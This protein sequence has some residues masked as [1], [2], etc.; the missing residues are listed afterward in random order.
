MKKKTFSVTDHFDGK[1]FLNMIPGKRSLWDVIKWKMKNQAT[2]WPKERTFKSFPAPKN[3]SSPG[4][5]TATFVN[6]STVL[7]QWNGLN[8][9]TDPIWSERC[10]PLNR[11]GPKRVHPPGIAL[12]DLPPID[13]I[14]LSHNHYDHL[15]LPTLKKIGLRDRPMI[16][17]GLGIKSLLNAQKI[18]RVHE[19]DWLPWKELQLFYV[20]AQHFSGRTIRTFDKSLWGGFILKMHGHTLYFAGDTGDGPHFQ[21]IREKF[22]KPY[23]SLLP[24]GAY[25]PRWFTRLVHMCPEEAVKAHQTLESEH[26]LA[27]HFGT[28]QL[29]DE[30]IDEPIHELENELK[31]Q[32]IPPSYFVGLEPGQS[33]RY[34]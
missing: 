13:L 22:G 7:I 9:I 3:R 23:L 1:R 31:K 14:L 29:T 33:K 25:K 2:P 30:G 18:N 19:L 34:L 21:M 4:E 10:G 12:H 5:L 28:F 6:H 11:V 17:T 20:P 15:D 32:G 16:A 27:I 8:I 26:S 24:I